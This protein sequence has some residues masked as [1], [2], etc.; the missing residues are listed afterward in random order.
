MYNA[1]FFVKKLPHIASQEKVSIQIC[2]SG[3]FE[4]CTYRVPN[5]K[6]R[7]CFVYRKGLNYFLK[8][9]RYIKLTLYLTLQ[10]TIE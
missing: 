9:S 2:V 6:Q 1:K 8:M 5:H 3:S 10:A 7:L 4:L